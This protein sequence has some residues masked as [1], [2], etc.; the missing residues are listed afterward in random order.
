MSTKE[1]L[2]INNGMLFS[3]IEDKILLFVATW[4]EM[5]IPTKTKN[6]SQ[7]PRD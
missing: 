4:M 1:M 5:E 6:K 7:E 2:Y 3:K